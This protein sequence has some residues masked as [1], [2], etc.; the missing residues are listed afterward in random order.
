MCAAMLLSSIVFVTS[1]ADPAVDAVIN[2]INAI[3]EIHRNEALFED[4]ACTGMQLNKS[5]ESPFDYNKCYYRIDYPD[6]AFLP[7]VDNYKKCL[8]WDRDFEISFQF[9]IKEHLTAGAYFGGCLGD[10]AWVGYMY[11][12]SEANDQRFFVAKSTGQAPPAAPSSL[13]VKSEKVVLDPDRLYT[14]TAVFD[15]TSIRVYLDGELMCDTINA[16]R[17]KMRLNFIPESVSYEEPWG[18]QKNWQFHLYPA[19]TISYLRSIE[20]KSLDGTMNVHSINDNI[21]CN[22]TVYRNISFTADTYI[23]SKYDILDAKDMYM[24]L[25]PA[26]KREVTNYDRLVAALR[27]YYQIQPAYGEENAISA[28]A[29]AVVDLI[30]AIGNVTLASEDAINAAENAYVA[31]GDAQKEE[32][33]NLDVLLCA[34]EMLDAL[35]DPAVP[36]LIADINAIAPVTL[37]SGSAIEAAENTY[38]DFNPSQKDLISNYN[39]LLSYRVTYDNL[40]VENVRSAIKA[41]GTVTKASKDAIENAKTLYNSLREDLKARLTDVYDIFQAAKTDI[42]ILLLEDR[43]YEVAEDITEIRAANEYYELQ[44]P[45][46]RARV[47]NKNYLDKRISDAANYTNAMQL[48]KLIDRINNVVYM[49]PGANYN[50]VEFSARSRKGY[51]NIEVR[52]AGTLAYSANLFGPYTASYDIVINK[53]L[54]NSDDMTAR[55]AAFTGNV[56]FGYN[57]L[58]KKFMIG[59]LQGFAGQENLTN[60]YG[61]SRVVELKLNVPYNITFEADEYHYAIYLN[62]ELMVKTTKIGHPRVAEANPSKNNNYFLFYPAGVDFLIISFDLIHN[63]EVAA[64]N[65]TSNAIIESPATKFGTDGGW[66]TSVQYF[67]GAYSDSG[68]RIETAYGRYQQLPSKYKAYVTNSDKLINLYN[69]YITTKNTHLVQDAIAAITAIGD[70]TSVTL[71]SLNAIGAAEYA[72]SEVPAEKKAEVT[73]YAD[74][75]AA[76]DAYD[77]I[78]AADFDARVEAVG[79]VTSEKLDT[80]RALKDEFDAM[81]EVQKSYV[82]KEALLNAKIKDCEEF[83]KAVPVVEAIYSFQGLKTANFKN[84]TPVGGVVR[85][86]GVDPYTHFDKAGSN[87]S[88]IMSTNRYCIEYDFVYTSYGDGRYAVIAGS[89]NQVLAGVDVGH[90]LVFIKNNG[91]LFDTLIDPDSYSDKSAFTFRT[92]RW[93]HVAVTYDATTVTVAIDGEERARLT[94]IE[95]SGEWNSWYIF[96]PHG[97]VEGYIDNFKCTCL[98]PEDER[99]DGIPASVTQEYPGDSIPETTIGKWNKDNVL[100]ARAMYNELSP[101]ARTAVTNYKTLTD[102]ERL[103]GIDSPSEASLA[104]IDMINLLSETSNVEE[105]EAV[106][107]AYFELSTAD[108]A[109]VTNYAK[110]EQLIQYL[111]SDEK[112]DDLIAKINALTPESPVADIKTCD[113]M[114]KSLDDEKKAKVTNYSRVAEMFAAKASQVVDMIAA[115]SEE[116]SEEDINAALDAYNELPD[117]V[118]EQVTNYLD[119]EALIDG[120]ADL[121][122]VRNVQALID[123]LTEDSDYAAVSAAEEAYNALTDEQKAKVKGFER[124]AELYAAMAKVVEDKI[125]ALTEESS[126]ED[127]N[128]ALDAYNELPDNV[129]EKVTNYLDLVALIAAVADLAP[130]RNVQALINALTEDSTYAAVSAAE[131]AYNALTDEQKAKV[132]GFERIA[133]LYAAMAKVVEDKIAALTEESAEDEIKAVADEYDALPEKIKALVSNYDHLEQFLKPGVSE[134]AA[135]VIDMIIEM[136]VNTSADKLKAVIDK[137]NALSDEDKAAVWNYDSLLM[138]INDKADAVAAKIGELPDA[139][140]IDI[141]HYESTV[142][143][144]VKDYNALP[145]EVQAKVTNYDKLKAAADKI[146]ALHEWNNNKKVNILNS[147]LAGLAKYTDEKINEFAKTPAI[148]IYYDFEEVDLIERGDSTTGYYSLDGDKENFLVRDTKYAKLDFDIKVTDVDLINGWPVLFKMTVESFDTGYVGY[149]FVNGTFYYAKVNGGGG[150]GMDHGY[151]DSPAVYNKADFELGVWH[152]MTITWDGPHAV[153]EFDGEKVLDCATEEFFAYVIIYPWLCNLEMTNVHLYAKDGSDTLSPFRN[154]T[155]TPTGWSRRGNDSGVTMLDYVKESIDAAKEAYNKLS[156]AEKA[157]VV[158]YEN[159][160]KVEKMIE[161]AGK[162][163]VTVVDGTA[164]VAA[165]AEG[166]TVT[167]TAADAPKGMIFDRWEIVSGDI[168]LADAKSATTT[169]KMP[170]SAVELK[171]LYQD[172]VIFGDVNGDGKLNAKDVTALMKFLVGSAPKNFVEDAADYDGNGKINAKDVTKL[173]KYLVSNP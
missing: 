141:Y 157:Q 112:V 52:G 42:R 109:T 29:L 16:S 13:A 50:G 8:L 92:N 30:D 161:E 101:L 86:T 84:T 166:E 37:D 65:L 39:D 131:E 82:T 31:L 73:N 26:Q 113:D 97:Q 88:G 91:G 38:K 10:V 11:S 102:T 140:Y 87:N 124:I 170:A 148:G 4:V 66:S 78:Y 106:Q 20:A 53:W 162:Y 130:V 165:A 152:H 32:V 96:K 94:D 44:T 111:S 156:D 58:E 136:D 74:L 160:A 98:V 72:Y 14:M 18:P 167:I 153:I 89:N 99:P 81:T 115:L 150:G 173:M 118:K 168:Q 129:K 28:D 100:N 3:G 9:T 154:A 142:N 103:L 75:V 67:N 69:E 95:M 68:Y 125:A 133:E 85:Y 77:H 146:A 6:G 171:A 22:D 79:D 76:R 63:G 12:S 62:G 132:K 49:E 122:A 137:Y 163:D 151:I 155:T 135:E 159:I 172:N 34:R 54:Y 55:I 105:A 56:A 17:P 33:Y 40:C 147:T 21:A 5:V 117:D 27:E 1:A 104:V 57:A 47:K 51:S 35:G 19:N 123:A 107:M 108:K 134:A 149:D 2:K 114:Y 110:L 46:T 83:D 138:I 41:I 164:N 25:T 48:V 64:E 143:A 43:N 116:S 71:A 139:Y 24:A 126:E 93:Y 120:G 15:S 158:G 59:E 121:A 45:A 70:P 90:G 169:F 7:N 145:A 80:I 128:A 119:L 61:E 36:Q 23:D 60:E 144:L 127:I